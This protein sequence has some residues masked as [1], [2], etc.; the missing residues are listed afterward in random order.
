MAAVPELHG[1]ELLATHAFPTDLGALAID[2]AL[3][4]GSD[5]GLTAMTCA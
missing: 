4:F 1:L 3:E 5:E 2:A